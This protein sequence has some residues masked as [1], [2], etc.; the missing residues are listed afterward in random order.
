M[1][2]FSIVQAISAELRRQIVETL[3]ATPDSDFGLAG[4]PDRIAAESP[5]SELP[6]DT[7]AS[8]YLYRVEIDPNLRNQRPLPD[9][10]NPDL[11][12]RPPLPL[13][14]RFL[15]TPIQPDENTNLLVLG[16][17]I[18]HFDAN[19][20]F[21]SVL[22]SPV[23]DGHGGAPA[24]LRVQFEMLSLSELTQLWSAFSTPFRLSVTLLVDIAAIESGRSPIPVRRVEEMVEVTGQIGRRR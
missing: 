17:V 14:L 9:R 15:L 16:R 12:H 19:P 5:A 20:V 3:D 11:F 13:R 2:D 21:D 4:N 6:A 10:S 24:R 8:L 22:G 1:A 23:G 7:V 18:Q